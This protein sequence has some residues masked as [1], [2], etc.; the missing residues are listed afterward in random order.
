[1]RQGTAK[2]ENVVAEQLEL[3]LADENSDRSSSAA[4]RKLQVAR[5]LDTLSLRQSVTSL[6]HWLKLVTWLKESDRSGG[7]SPLT[8]ALLSRLSLRQR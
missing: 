2:K 1:M 8:T 3:K 4:P 5:G 7:N 6:S